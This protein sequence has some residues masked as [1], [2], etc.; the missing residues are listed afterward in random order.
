MCKK[1]IS[2]VVAVILICTLSAC[3]K[4]ELSGTYVSH[5]DMFTQTLIFDGDNITLTA[6]GI[7]AHGTYEIK[8]DRITIKY[9]LFGIEQTLD[10]TFSKS[11]NSI[12][13]GGTKFIKQ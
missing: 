10:N 3:G 7:N 13:I 9:S 12:T 11:N 2:L 1:V 4:Q 5:E 8:G 6:F